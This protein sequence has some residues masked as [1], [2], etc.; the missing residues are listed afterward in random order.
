MGAIETRAERFVAS[1]RRR[2]MFELITAF[3]L[4]VMFTSYAS[5][6][7]YPTVRW[8]AA[9]VV[10]TVAASTVALLTL[11]RV[12]PV[13]P[14]PGEDLRTVLQ[15]RL[16]EHARVYTWA[17]LWGILPVFLASCGFVLGMDQVVYA[18]RSPSV[19]LPGD[20]GLAV[21][22]AFAATVMCMEWSKRLRTEAAAL[23]NPN[24]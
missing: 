16:V 1:A 4:A 6:F 17:P 7:E 13:T 19:M 11:A 24:G 20:L 15:A 9:A 10:G 8:S 22:F 18:A 21:A 3:V 12:G 23:A 5:W 2:R 14:A